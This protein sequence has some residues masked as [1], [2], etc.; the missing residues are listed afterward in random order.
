MYFVV[1]ASYCDPLPMTMA[2]VE[3][4]LPGHK[5]FVARG[6]R[7]N[8][9]LCAGPKKSNNGGF[10]IIQAETKSELED[11]ISTDPFYIKGVQKYEITEFT[12]YDYQ[13]YIEPWL[14]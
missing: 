9:V 3:E 10:I 5:E 6:I 7:A 11:Y 1:S 13:Q 12:P 2:E 8:K 4:L 14:K